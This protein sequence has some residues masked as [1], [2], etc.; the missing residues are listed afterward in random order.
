MSLVSASIRSVMCAPLVSDDRVHGVL[1]I[2]TS[3]QRSAF[4]KGDLDMLS[5]VAMQCAVAIENARAYKKRQEYS[6]SLYE[7]AR[8]T[9]RLSAFLDRDK[10]VREAVKAACKLVGATKGSLILRKEGTDKLRLVYA[11]GMGR[12]V[13]TRAGFIDRFVAS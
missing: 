11:I 10:I 13:A 6:R 3:S 4:T 2:D 1:Q 7:L 8:A 5:A 9:Q 12:D